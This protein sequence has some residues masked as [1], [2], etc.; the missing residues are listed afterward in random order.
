MEKKRH[1]ADSNNNFANNKKSL[2]IYINFLGERGD[3]FL[4]RWFCR[5][6]NESLQFNKNK[7][8]TFIVSPKSFFNFVDSEKGGEIRAR[9]FITH[10]KKWTCSTHAF[11][12]SFSL[13]FI[14][15]TRLSLYTFHY[16]CDDE[17]MCSFEGK[18]KRISSPRVT[19]LLVFLEIY[20]D[21]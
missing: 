1:K 11:F 18:A 20:F 14:P 10:D 16:I 6:A 15:C 5:G 3:L 17:I 21:K 7:S 8:T 4:F 2:V 13:L 19:N 9:I 12:P